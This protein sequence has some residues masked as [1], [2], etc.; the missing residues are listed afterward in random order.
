MSIP[1]S[2]N[3]FSDAFQGVSR[4]FRVIPGVC[5]RFSGVAAAIQEVQVAS[6]AFHRIPGSFRSV[7]GMFQLCQLV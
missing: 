3:G 4:G 7:S 2:L 5:H 1:G 6:R